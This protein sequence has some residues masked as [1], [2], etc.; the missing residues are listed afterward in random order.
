MKAAILREFG[1]PDV[2]KVEEVATPRPGPGQVLVRVLA[3]GLNRL[4]HY[5][6]EGSVTRD[7]QLP[8]V[9]GSDAAGIVEALGE[10]VTSFSPSERVIP[11][12]GYPL[13]DADTEV[14][15]ISLAPSYAIR[16][17][18]EWGAYAQFMSVPERW[19]VR[20]ETGLSPEEA[21]TLPMAVVTTVRAV[22]NVG[23]V[24]DGDHVLVH[25]GASGTGS[26]AI[27][28]AKALGAK[29]AAT[30]RSQEK[31]YFVQSLGAELVIS[32][33]DDDFVEKT[34]AWT[35]G[36]GVDVAID[37]LGGEI[38]SRTLDALRPGG[39][40]VSV[41]MVTGLEA[42]IQLRPFFFAQKEI[43]GTLM[44]DVDDLKWGL[45]RVREG[46]IR[47]VLD[48]TY[49]LDDIAKAHADLAAGVALGN[50]VVRP[51]GSAA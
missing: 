33:T 18:V 5:L 43:R 46:K 38:F 16:G 28:V 49:D 7:L 22:R 35:A 19:L 2:L 9:L 15:P 29:V 31:A 4:D 10:G 11:M 8:H 13:E 14:R 24:K 36:R 42:T 45:D 25:A 26:M 17:I 44:G 48:R 27:Q 51:W 32:L 20:D 21:A 34:K 23:Q 47:P 6:R 37:N 41:G 50:I 1:D 3:A 30:V 39:R 12:P 40:L